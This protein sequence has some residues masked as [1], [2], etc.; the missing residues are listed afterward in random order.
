MPITKHDKQALEQLHSDWSG[1]YKGR[2]EDYFAL[3]YLT[4]K[5]DREVEDV[6]GQ[7]CFGG[8]DYG[9]DAYH[10][11]RAARNLYLYQFKWS[12][13]HNLFRESIERLAKDGLDRVFGD[14]LVDPNQN[15][16]LNTLRAEL[17]ESRSLIERV[18]IHFVFKG[19]LEAAENSEGLA[20]RK[21]NLESKSHLLHSYFGREDVELT[22]EFITDRRQPPVAKPAESHVMAFTNSAC[23]RSE[24]GRRDMYVGFVPLMDLYRIYRSLQHRFL[25]RNIRSGLSA[26][27][28]PNRKIREALSDII[29]KQKQAPDVFS[30]F[31]NGV[32]L[33]AEHF[34][35]DG[36][37]AVAKVPRLL[38]G[39]DNHKRREISRR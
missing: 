16:I 37:R 39:A 25:D 34:H 26:D 36:G 14:S 15:D 1:T 6:A 22:V 19:E 17:K 23:I 8:C 30:F 18:L 33:A 9:I 38:N 35:V 12:E 24:D 3:L 28:P 32:T 11:D 31:H 27:N 20:Y 5:F 2:A 7:V 4:K 10:I 13:N 21:E 29:L